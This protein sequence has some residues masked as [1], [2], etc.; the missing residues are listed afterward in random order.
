MIHSAYRG[1]INEE[2]S[3]GGCFAHGLC[4]VKPAAAEKFHG[5]ANFQLKLK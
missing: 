2:C 5:V 4:I 3:M 1:T